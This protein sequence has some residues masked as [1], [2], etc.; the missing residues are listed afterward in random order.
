MAERRGTVWLLLG[1]LAWVVVA[2]IGSLAMWGMLALIDGILGRRGINAIPHP[3]RLVFT[4]L[5]GYGF[6]GTLLLG[7]LRQGR[8]IGSGDWRAGVGVRRIKHKRLIVLFCVGMIFWLIG[9]LALTSAV[10]ALREF[11]KSMT[12]EFLMADLGDASPGVMALLLV[13]VVVMAPVAEELFFRGWLWEA[14]CRRG[15]GVTTTA[16]L[17]AIPWLLLHGIES[18]GRILFLLPAAVIFPLARHLGGGVL[19]SLTVHFT[20]NLSVVLVQAIA[21]LVGHE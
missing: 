13:L 11:M 19:A 7:A 6:H 12:P 3:S 20:N 9:M 16:V 10:P 17:T 1:M 21:M 8:R 2:I 14:L 5:G 4:L 15:H 18:P